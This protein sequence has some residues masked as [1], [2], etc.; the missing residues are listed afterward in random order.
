MV[1]HINYMMLQKHY[2]KEKI[3]DMQITEV[4]NEE[5]LSFCNWVAPKDRIKQYGFDITRKIIIYGI[6]MHM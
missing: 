5:E 3:N 1:L 6:H 2:T 4:W